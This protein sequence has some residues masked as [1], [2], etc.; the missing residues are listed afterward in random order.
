MTEEGR[1]SECAKGRPH[2]S[3]LLIPHLPQAL[4]HLARRPDGFLRECERRLACRSALLFDGLEHNVRGCPLRRLHMPRELSR[5]ASSRRDEIPDEDDRRFRV[6]VGWLYAVAKDAHVV[7]L[8]CRLLYSM[9][10][11]TAHEAG[12][13]SPLRTDELLALRTSERRLPPEGTDRPRRRTL[14]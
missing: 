4:L 14:C 3:V 9:R 6:G 13:E 10:R 12:P 8:I 5:Y 7:F 2:L 1:A 11:T